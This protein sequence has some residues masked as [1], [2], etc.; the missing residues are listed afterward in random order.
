[1]ARCI[2]ADQQEQIMRENDMIETISLQNDLEYAKPKAD[3]M[4]EDILDLL[5]EMTSYFADG[6]KFTDRIKE[7]K[8]RYDL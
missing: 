5:E 3:A 8:Y 4:A 2:D 7:I 1:M 6:N